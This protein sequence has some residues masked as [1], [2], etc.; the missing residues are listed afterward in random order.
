MNSK[1]ILEVVSRYRSFFEMHEIQKIEYPGD[2]LLIHSSDALKHG[3]WMLDEIE[4]FVSAGDIGKA[5]VWLGFVQCCLWMD[6]NCTIN[7]LRDHNRP[8]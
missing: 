4:K 5:Q 2:L 3:H 7:E 6:R 8:R 1:K